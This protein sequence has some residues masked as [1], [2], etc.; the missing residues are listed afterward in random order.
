[1]IVFWYRPIRLGR[2]SANQIANILDDIP[3]DSDISGLSDDS[4]NDESF[5]PRG[6]LA[7]SNSEDEPE[8]V[9]DMGPVCDVLGPYGD[10]QDGLLPDLEDASAP[11]LP[12]IPA[13]AQAV[14]RRTLVQ[15]EWY[16][17]DLPLQEMPA[18]SVNPRDIADGENEVGIFLKLFGS[19]NITLLTTQTNM[20]RSQTSINRNKPAPAISETEIWQ[21]IGILMYMSI[22]S[23][24]NIRLFWRNSL[25][26]NMVAVVM[27]RDC[28]LM[29]VSYFHLSDTSL[30]PGRDSPAY[31][32]LFK[33]EL[34]LFVLAV[35]L[36]HIMVLLLCFS[37]LLYI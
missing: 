7:S 1:L 3:S 11:V 2:L 19:N 5:R 9:E 23:M 14:K 21:A 30:Q 18:S 25:R 35:F 6:E 32:R 20:V 12:H 29:I 16:K 4:N 17:A 22:V 37:T 8:D 31:D 13:D 10:V 36:Y 33:V 27:S 26:N 34:F 28:F 15:R 24:P